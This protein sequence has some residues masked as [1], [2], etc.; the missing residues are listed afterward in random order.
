MLGPYPKDPMHNEQGNLIN[1]WSGWINN[2]QNLVDFGE[3]PSKE[4]S[5]TAA[6]GINITNPTMRIISETGGNITITKNPQISK[7]HD[8]QVVT[9][10]GL[11]NVA[12]ITMNDGNGIVLKG[13]SPIVISKNVVIQFHFN[14]SQ[15]VWI[16]NFRNN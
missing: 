1:S 13:A 10:E 4:T 2:L 7:G 11:D 3:P 8:N 14:L 9:L 6:G 5:I 15:N 12:T 16:E